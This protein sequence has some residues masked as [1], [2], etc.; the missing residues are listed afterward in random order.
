MALHALRTYDINWS[1]VMNAPVSVTDTGTRVGTDAAK[2]VTGS[3]WTATGASAGSSNTTGSYW[4]ATGAS[5]GSS[6]TT[7]GSWTATG[8]N[9]GYYNTTGGSWTAT[10]MN[11]GYS[12][13]TG[14]NWMAT[15]MNAGFYNTTGSNWTATGASAGY[16]NTTGGNWTATGMNAGYYNTTGGSWTATGV[17]AGLSNTTG[18]SWTATGASAGYSNTTG[19][20]WTASGVNAGRFLLDGTT[21]ATVFDN[22]VYLGANT[23][24]SSNTEGLTNETVLGSDA[25]GKGSNTVQIGSEANLMVYI[26][27]Q[28]NATQQTPSSATAVGVAGTICADANYIYHCTATNVWKRSPLTTW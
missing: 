13:T 21:G 14:S 16:S 8:M 6:N 22:C 12:S 4:T 17:N 7:G 9:A 25:K 3:Y 28:L 1:G 19:S 24:V 5:A 18:G 27:G 2:F 26:A 20:N 15:G 11:A 23:K 10:G